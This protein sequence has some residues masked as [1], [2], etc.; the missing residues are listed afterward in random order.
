MQDNNSTIAPLPAEAPQQ[1]QEK[2]VAF[3]KAYASQIATVVLIIAAVGIAAYRYY[4]VAE[5]QKQEATEK[6]FSARSTQELD[7]LLSDNASSH[8]APL[9]LLKMAKL[10]FNAG[11]YDMAMSK[12][13]EFKKKYSQHDLADAAEMGKLHCMEARNQTQEALAGFIAFTKAKPNNFLYAEAVIAQ[14]RCL[15]QLGQK[16]EAITVYEDF[17]AAHPKS[18]W[19]S[20]VEDLMKALKNKPSENKTSG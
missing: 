19:T 16:K 9:A 10:Q 7:L 2:Q 6:L 1:E 17:I 11:N 5:R 4:G 18:A 14:G 15:E 8:V 20:K 13:D 3:F 12:Y